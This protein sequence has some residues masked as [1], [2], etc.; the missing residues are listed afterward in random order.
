M[1]KKKFSL[2]EISN[3]KDVLMRDYRRKKKIFDLKY[4]LLVNKI[5]QLASSILIGI[6]LLALLIYF[7]YR[8][9]LV[10]YQ[11]GSIGINMSRNLSGFINMTAIVT[12]QVSLTLVVFPISSLMINMENKY[13]Y[14]KNAI[15]CV[16]HRRGIFS[17]NTFLITLFL[18]IFANLYLFINESSDALIMIFFICTIL[19]VSTFIYRFSRLTF[20]QQKIKFA[21]LYRYYR[22]NTK[23]L[24]KSRPSKPLIIPDFE[25]FRDVTI[26]HIQEKRELPYRENLFYYFSLLEMC[27]F[28]QKKEVQEYYTEGAVK[29]GDFISHI[30]LIVEE[31]LSNN[32]TYEALNVFNELYYKL[33]YFQIVINPFDFSIISEDFIEKVKY[34]NTESELR[35]Y[36]RSLSVMIDRSITQIHLFTVI[37]LSYCR[38]YESDMIYFSFSNRLL[39]KY[40][41]AIYENIHLS[42]RDKKK[43]FV[44]LL[45]C[46]TINKLRIG[47]EYR[48]IDD[49]IENKPF[50]KSLNIFP[51]EIEAEPMALMVLKMF[52]HKDDE[53]IATFLRA[54]VARRL[55]NA[56]KAF[57]T[58]SILEILFRKNKRSYFLDLEIDADFSTS[59]LAD[60]IFSVQ[61]LDLNEV[62]EL[63]KL[64]SEKYMLSEIASEYYVSGSYYGFHPK[65]RF[66]KNVVDT[67]FLSI[68]EKSGN[69]DLD[70]FIQK[71]PN[72]EIVRDN[73]IYNLIK[74]KEQL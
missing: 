44:D 25:Q 63:Y 37:D 8:L 59:I 17:L 71:F 47:S 52:E 19:L 22:T 16:F 65:F 30:F 66:S 10:V 57:T 73:E 31:L 54:R 60:R 67:Y 42:D 48:N 36:G 9:E 70:N 68:I 72:Q 49:F 56:V 50:Q 69:V 1:N 32:Q 18:L 39:E 33:N 51:I 38:L 74:C 53:S 64:V 2:T 21:L 61:K 55:M 5:F 13:I 20:A 6:V 27:F 62:E 34:M 23:I 45:D 28:N 12:A 24:K 11:E 40:Y 14:G 41:T 7:L 26:N 4:S 35:K 15:D 29:K 3:Y 58:L 43:V 46:L